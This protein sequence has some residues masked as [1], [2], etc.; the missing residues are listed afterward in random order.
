MIDK[1]IW[2]IRNQI[3]IKECDSCRTWWS[4]DHFTIVVRCFCA[5]FLITKLVKEADAFHV[6]Y[7]AISVFLVRGDF[8]FS[9]FFFFIY[10][11]FIFR[12]FLFFRFFVLFIFS[13]FFFLLLFFFSF[14]PDITL[15]DLIREIHIPINSNTST[16]FIFHT[17]KDLMIPK[18]N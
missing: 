5:I 14:R 7:I 12:L 2:K 16:I 1:K 9:L 8:C 11:L 10:L 13:I 18:A 15:I 17:K 4:I 3:S 6:K